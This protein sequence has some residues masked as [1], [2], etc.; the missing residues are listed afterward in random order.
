MSYIFIFLGTKKYERARQCPGGGPMSA[1][2]RQGKGDRM[3]ISRKS[4]SLV[5]VL[6]W[7]F[8]QYLRDLI[9]ISHSLWDDIEKIVHVC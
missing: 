5:H 9:M 6:L 7:I 4:K 1:H 8:L 2:E 3:Q